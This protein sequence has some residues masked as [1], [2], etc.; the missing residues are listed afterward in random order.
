MFRKMQYLLRVIFIVMLLPYMVSAATTADS[1]IGTW[2]YVAL[3]HGNDDTWNS[4]AG[5][6]T[7]NSDG[8]GSD[9][10][11]S[12]ANGTQG[13]GTETFSY[14]VTVHGD[15][16]MTVIYTYPDRTG[17]Q[18][19]ILSDDGNTL[20]VDGTDDLSNQRWR[21]MGKMNTSGYANADL[22]GEYYVMGYEYGKSGDYVAKSGVIAFDGNGAFTFSGK[23]NTNG[24]V[25]DITGES[26]AYSMGANG[27]F[28][29]GNSNAGGLCGEKKAALVT[30][31]TADK[32]TKYVAM[33]KGDKAYSNSDLSGTWAISIFG[34]N[35]NTTFQSAIGTATCDSSGVCKVSFREQDNGVVSYEAKSIVFSVSADGSFGASLG[36][37]YPSYAAAI[38]NDGNMFVLNPSFG[39]DPNGSAI[40]NTR[41]LV[42]GLKCSACGDLTTPLVPMLAFTDTDDN[43]KANL[44]LYDP[45]SKTMNTVVQDIKA[46][47]PKMNA[48]QTKGL[49]TDF[50]KYNTDEGTIKVYDI[51]S[52]TTST[53][54]TVKTTEESADFTAD[55]KILF[56]DKSDGVIKKM[57]LDGSGVTTVATPEASYKFSVLWLAPNRQYVAA[58]ENRQEGSDYNTGNKEKGVL[59]SL[60][61]GTIFWESDEYLGE[62]NLLSWRADSLAFFYGFHTFN[63]TD[64]VYKS[65]TPQHMVLEYSNGQF[66]VNDLA[67]TAFSNKGQNIAFYTESGKLLS[68]NKRAL[69]DAKTG[70]LVKDVSSLV[71]ALGKAMF[72]FDNFGSIYFAGLDG[73]NFRRF[74]EAGTSVTP[75]VQAKLTIE[76][77]SA[78]S[79]DGTGT[80]KVTAT[81]IKC[82]NAEDTTLTDCDQTYTKA[83]KVILKATP[84]AGS[85]FQSWSGCDSENASAKTCTVNMSSSDKTVTATFEPTPR[86]TVT[87]SKDGNGEGTVKSTQKGIEKNGI[88]CDTNDTDCDET[89]VEKTNITLV[90]TPAKDGKSKF[91]RWEGAACGA[92][93]TASCRI[94][95]ISA[96][97]EVTAVFGYPMMTLSDETLDFSPEA[98]SQTFS[99]TNSGSGSLT[100]WFSIGGAD[101]RSFRIYNSENKAVTKATVAEGESSEFEVVFGQSAKQSTTATLTI[102]SSDPDN[103]IGTIQLTGTK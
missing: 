63:V 53:I 3:K 49:F 38:G 96:D 10:Y 27:F 47:I 51:A 1:L 17:K 21:T 89:Y 101:K 98:V 41:T 14:A 88:T 99:I 12:N 71:P 70:A 57:N 40:N 87:V 24:I 68:L 61:D 103:R 90:A 32:L 59:V 66:N 19:V 67:N 80:G 46:T 84:D 79:E 100:V 37:G 34:D 81:G 15:G 54:T 20:V 77:E 44:Y 16:S 82:A 94:S 64:G 76:V 93:K 31:A 5:S 7:F 52:K 97:A 2:G 95:K 18:R 11:A 39:P 78:E 43:W 75:S 72:G 56:I 29:L 26:D 23:A 6:M 85:S 65:A 25:S 83:T 13:S 36:T 33:K 48:T 8:T 69:F 102:K 42:V 22:N 73:S 58:I 86:F 35:N 28:S 55:G 91:V 50:D 4:R 60:T 74:S 30:S 45:A 92:A 62:W 9:S